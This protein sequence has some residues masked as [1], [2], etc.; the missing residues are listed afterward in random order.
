[1]LLNGGKSFNV[2]LCSNILGGILSAEQIGINTHK[3][4]EFIYILDFLEDMVQ[5][6]SRWGRQFK[7]TDGTAQAGSPP[8]N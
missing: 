7:M 8:P 5:S 2:L 3:F 6:K 1:M 4:L